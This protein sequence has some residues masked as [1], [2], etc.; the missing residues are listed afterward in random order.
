MQSINEIPLVS[1]VIA[2]YNSSLTIIEALES[3]R[4]QSY[5]NIE[6]VIT[7]DCS[8]DNTIEICRKWLNK[9]SCELF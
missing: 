9:H 3:V 4:K 8:Q 1:I 2:T 7:D 5:K 6:I